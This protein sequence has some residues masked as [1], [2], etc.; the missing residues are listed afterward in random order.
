MHFEIKM[1]YVYE[2]AMDIASVS[3][4]NNL[5]AVNAVIQGS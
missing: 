4:W 5:N 1:R 2:T 3:N